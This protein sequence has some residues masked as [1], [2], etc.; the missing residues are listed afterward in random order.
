MKMIDIT[1]NGDVLHLID[2]D[3]LPSV[4]THH[5]CI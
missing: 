2:V 1:A 3:G 4:V 5:I